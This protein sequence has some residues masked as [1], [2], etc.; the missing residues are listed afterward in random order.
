[1]LIGPP[2]TPGGL[3]AWKLA[4]ELER[5]AAGLNPGWWI[6]STLAAAG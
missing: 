1:V 3:P 5:L 4:P 6:I 2:A